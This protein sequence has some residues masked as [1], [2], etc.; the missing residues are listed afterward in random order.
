MMA[1]SSSS[2]PVMKKAPITLVTTETL[3]IDTVAPGTGRSSVPRITPAIAVAALAGGGSTVTV[4][5]RCSTSCPVVAVKTNGCVPTC[6]GDGVNVNAPVAGLKS[7]LAGNGMGLTVTPAGPPIAPEDAYIAG[8]DGNCPPGRAAASDTRGRLRIARRGSLSTSYFWDGEWKE[9]HQQ[10]ISDD[11]LGFELVVRRILS[12]AA[13]RFSLDNLSVRTVFPDRP[14]CLEELLDDFSGIVVDPRFRLEDPYSP[15]SESAGRLNLVKVDGYS[16]SV[17]GTLDSSRFVVCGDFDL[18]VEYALT[19]WP[20][21]RSGEHAAGLALVRAADHTLVAAVERGRDAGGEAGAMRD[22]IRVR[23]S[24]GQTITPRTGVQGELQISRRADKVT[25]L[26]RDD[27][28]WREL[29]GG[30][31]TRD[32]L[33]FQYYYG[34]TDEA[35]RGTMQFDNLRFVPR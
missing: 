20:A 10:P 31:I 2:K 27:G 12:S 29:F 28:D 34:A 25:L 24:G 17:G 11:V 5:A 1:G 26:A 7:P 8:G 19:E 35:H 4:T 3:P 22:F 13:L 21:P 16:G 14:K 18:S 23:T 33:S 6:S 15:P 9:L 32:H 30:A